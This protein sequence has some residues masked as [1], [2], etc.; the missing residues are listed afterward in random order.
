MQPPPAHVWHSGPTRAV[1]EAFGTTADGLTAA[2]AHT[3]LETVGPNRLPQTPPTPRW[4]VFARQFNSPLIYVLA[5]AAVIS[6]AIGEYTD[7]GF[8]GAVLL[9][10]AL[11][12]AFQEAKA[13]RSSRA[14]Q[15]MLRGRA[16]VMRDGDAVEVD[17]EDVVPG[18]VVLL[19]S[20][21]RIPA[22]VRL[23]SAY[24]LEV[25]ESLMT[26]ESIPV[27]KEPE[28]TGHADVPVADRRN[29]SWAGS[30][31][32]R[33]R[34]RAVVTATGALTEVGRLARAVSAAAGGDPPLV[35]RVEQFTRVIGLAVL[36]AAIPVVLI[37][38]FVR[39]QP[40]S[41][42]FLF[43]VA[44]AVSAIPEGLPVA[45]TVALAVA[46]SRMAGR[47]AIVRRLAA[48]EGLGSCTLV[49]TDKTGTLTCNALTV[50]RA[51]LP[52][53]R[54]LSV[55][56]E[57]YSP[58][59]QIH[60]GD[61][62][63]AD[64]T[65]G[66]PGE[67]AD[68]PA[69]RRLATAVAL[70]N[71]GS[72]HPRAEGGWTWLGDPTDVALLAFSAKAG[73]PRDSIEGHLPEI[74]AIPFEPE[75][76]YAAT[77]HRDGEQ[78]RV[79]VKGAPEKVL[80]MCR[81]DDPGARDEALRLAHRLAEEG[82]RVL[83]AAD[84]TS[85]TAVPAEQTPEEPEALTFL[86]YVAM[87]DPLRPGV[88]RAVARCREAGVAV[89]MVTGDHPVTALAIGRELGLVDADTDDEQVLTGRE[90]DGLD[91][92][93]LGKAVE[94]VRVFARVSP[95]QKLR[96]VE[97]GTAAG[98]FVAVTGD[99]VN[100]AP[101]L[102]ASHIGV[103]MGREG[104]DVAREA[105]D[106]VLSDDEFSTIVA[107]IE[108]GRV[109]YDN[110]RKVIYLLVSTGAAEIVLVL[111]AVLTGTPIP[112]LP[113]QLLW[114][115]LVTNGIQDVALAF[116]PREADVLSRKPR[117]TTEG[118]FNQLMLE[119]TILAALVMGCMAFGA[120]RWML[121]HG[122]EASAARNGVLTLMVLFEIVHIGNARSET[123]SLFR[124][125]PWRS[126]ILLGGSILAFGLHLLVMH[127]TPLQGILGA[128]SLT[129][130]Q[131]VTLAGLA[132]S[133][134]VVMELHKL[135]WR[136]RHGAA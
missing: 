119:R 92:A 66:A 23:L 62:T 87:M 124:L 107:G 53:G 18:D 24:G 114:L 39:G 29:M 84:G 10:N 109:A 128:A 4:K 132:V 14:L 13:E 32:A 40:L 37:G 7:A 111:L 30:V 81:F 97:A 8:I 22:D 25:D 28:W 27:L 78:T 103:A 46:S 70:C 11:I 73:V 38:V 102:R 74:N 61:L 43:G 113:V 35:V 15:Q 80:E 106:V 89:S 116:E 71:E 127:G 120:W 122:W 105:A 115:N 83:S 93:A 90:V 118:I 3:R 108:E 64:Q 60:L 63:G 110:V 88:Q 98:H 75:A 16:T 82:F 17:A 85:E 126:P 50:R 86:G 130:T 1:L 2:E 125:P 19:E 52:D 136:A 76:R 67:P 21:N 6:A 99:G 9:L 101:A 91:D 33:G 117:P 79:F 69:V 12:G 42:M 135:S 55:T 58:T 112:L 131:W 49:A 123:I 96:I 51:V 72:L 94:R 45:M 36:A 44:M 121:D 48:V 95:H 54:V 65:E 59:G 133:I 100:D 5:A 26:G 134:A 68:S 104:T 31:V 77:W 34:G 47:G 57:G 129:G 56:G 20:G 41:E